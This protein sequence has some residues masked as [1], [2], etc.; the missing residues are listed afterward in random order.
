M[1]EA[2]ARY[3]TPPAERDANEP[4]R[5]TDRLMAQLLADWQDSPLD[6]E[7]LDGLLEEARDTFSARI[8]EEERRALRY[9]P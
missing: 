5:E 8:A 2:E 1:R 9:G 4:T 3:L 6:P 7:L